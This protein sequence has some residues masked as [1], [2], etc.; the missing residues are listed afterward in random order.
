MKKVFEQFLK[1]A[2]GCVA[3]FFIALVIT[4]MLNV[5]YHIIPILFWLIEIATLLYLGYKFGNE[6][7]FSRK[8]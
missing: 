4:I 5:I 3:I 2:I 6:F 1:M 7:L 8:E